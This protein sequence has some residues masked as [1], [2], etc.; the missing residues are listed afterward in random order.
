MQAIVTGVLMVIG[1]AAV[2][3]LGLAL[4]G[5]AWP[6]VDG[7]RQ[8]QEQAVERQIALTDALDAKLGPIVSPVVTRPMRGPWE[9]CIGVPFLQPVAVA[10]VVAVVDDLFSTAEPADSRSYRLVL[11]ALDSSEEDRAP[12]SRWAAAKPLAAA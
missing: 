4:A 3:V 2:L 12:T 7:A 5:G 1:M 8:R 6:L 9:I 11:R 10:T